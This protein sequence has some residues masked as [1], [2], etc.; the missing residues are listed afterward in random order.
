MATTENMHPNC[1]EPPKTQKTKGAVTQPFSKGNTEIEKQRLPRLLLNSILKLLTMKLKLSLLVCA[2][3]MAACG[4]ERQEI[5]VCGVFEVMQ[6][7]E[8]GAYVSAGYFDSVDVKS[9]T[10][11]ICWV[12]GA[13]MRVTGRGVMVFYLPCDSLNSSPKP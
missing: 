2:F 3:W 8:S 13:K 5:E 9:R 1:F 7:A 11:A 10:D 4:Q 12:D 6:R